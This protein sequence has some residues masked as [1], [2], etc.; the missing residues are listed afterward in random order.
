MH[1]YDVI[2]KLLLKQSAQQTL[3]QL[4]GV[5]I[6]RWLR[7]ELPKVQNLRVDLLGE[8]VDGTLLQ[9]ELQSSNDRDMP[10]RMAEYSL[11]IY[12]HFARFAQQIV[13]YV[14]RDPLRM[15]DRLQG[16]RFSLEYTLVDMREL[17][18]EALLASAQTSDNVIA[19]LQNQQRAVADI[20]RKVSEAGIEQRA[21]YLQ[22]LL[23]LA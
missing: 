23:T 22:A 19:S 3:R 16:P 1:E 2:L 10:L 8:A 9:L 6:E 11:G 18:S 5:V 7:M 15:T 14:G 17:N 4:A 20:V 21:F 12:R 13:V